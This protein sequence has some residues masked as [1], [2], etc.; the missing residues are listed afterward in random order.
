[1]VEAYEKGEKFSTSFAIEIISPTD[2][3]KDIE[4]KIEDYF[5]AKV[6]LVWYIS[7]M[8]QQIYVYHSPTDLKILKGDDICSAEPIIE[9][10]SFKVQDMFPKKK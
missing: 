2:K 4:D 7:P 8:Q 1:M 6:A 9:G 10:F 3:M 5:D